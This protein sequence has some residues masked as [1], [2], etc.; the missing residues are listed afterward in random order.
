[1]SEAYGVGKVF[2]PLNFTGFHDLA[3]GARATNVHDITVN[4]RPADDPN[5]PGP[6][7]SKR[8]RVG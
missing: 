3:I 1:M 8:Q 6:R 2:E 4:N 7:P 5:S